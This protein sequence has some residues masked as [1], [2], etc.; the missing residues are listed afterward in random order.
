LCGVFLHHHHSPDIRDTN[1]DISGNMSNLN[2]TGVIL[3]E[4]PPSGDGEVTYTQSATNAK[5]SAP[6]KRASR[7]C[8]QC[9]SSRTKCDGKHP[10]QRCTGKCQ[11]LLFSEG[12]VLG[13]RVPIV[14]YTGVGVT[15]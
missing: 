13:L 2:S 7:A 1:P 8:D 5:K 12:M 15:V 4:Q 3:P 10:C 11:W 6:A 9:S 14:D